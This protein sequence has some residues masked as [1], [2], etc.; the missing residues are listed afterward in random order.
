MSSSLSQQLANA[1][2]DS[3]MTQREKEEWA[4]FSAYMSEEQ[5]KEFIELL[6]TQNT[7]EVEELKKLYAQ[8]TTSE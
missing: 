6:N 1:L 7:Q 4:L 2:E 5:V 8:L 3:V